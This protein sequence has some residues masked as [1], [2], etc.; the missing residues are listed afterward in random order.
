M[1]THPRLVIDET[2]PVAMPPIVMLE[3]VSKHFVKPLNFVA[4]IASA[5]GAGWREEAVFAVDGVSL[6][7]NQGEIVGLVGESGCGKST[8]GRVVAGIL[9]FSGGKMFYQGEDV[10]TMLP[11]QRRVVDLDIQMIFQDSLASLNR[12]MRVQDIIGEAP[13]FHN[14][15]TSDKLDEYIDDIMVRVGLHPN[16]KRC[17]PHQ[18]SNGQ[19]QRISI[20]RALAVKPRF[21]VCDEA[22]AALDVSMRM[23]ILNL[24]LKLRDDLGLTYL[25][26]SQD[27]SVVEYFSDRVAIM[28]RGCLVE[29]APTEKLFAAPNHPYTQWLLTEAPPVDS[30]HAYTAIE[31]EIALPPDPIRGCQ[32]YPHCPY[33]MARCRETPPPLKEIAP[34]R[35]SAC[36][37]NDEKTS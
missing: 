26:I 23:Q 27:L 21:I 1:A 22:V 18:F 12:L 36:Y 31:G 2:A 34:S 35:Y 16:H 7:I 28:Y 8:L 24:L 32:F 33:A 29:I 9:P 25:F 3:R 30:R 14:I 13:L 6:S 15:V 17:F 11:G 4:R 20:A 5:L 10:E 37:L 19:R